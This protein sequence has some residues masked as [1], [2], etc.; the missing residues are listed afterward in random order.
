MPIV[1]AEPLAG[2]RGNAPPLTMNR[3]ETSHD[4]RY[5]STMPV[6]AQCRTVE[7]LGDL[8]AALVEVLHHTQLFVVPVGRP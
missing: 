8:G 4:C 7:R 1:L 5:L 3:F 6:A 2:F